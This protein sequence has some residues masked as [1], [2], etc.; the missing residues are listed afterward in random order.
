[1]LRAFLLL[2]GLCLCSV[3]DTGLKGNQISWLK[4]ILNGMI[5]GQSYQVFYWG[6]AKFDQQFWD[7]CFTNVYVQFLIKQITVS[8][9]LFFSCFDVGRV[10]ITLKIF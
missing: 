7:N 6:K 8:N 3:V 2:L 4:H 5:C 10:I 9:I 1:M